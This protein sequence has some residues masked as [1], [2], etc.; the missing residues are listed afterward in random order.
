MMRV[1]LVEDNPAEACLTREGFADVGLIHELRVV[2]DGEKATAFLR[3]EGNYANEEVPDLVLLDLN[4]PKKC[5]HEVLK[6]I[7]SDPDLLHIPVLVVTNS[8]AMDDIEKVYRSNGNCYLVKPPDLND[9]FSMVRRIVDF[10]WDTAR[11]PPA[12]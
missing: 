9:F 4:L 7:K 1:L 6:D 2:D 11:L 10:W 12:V 5:G 3:R 8:H